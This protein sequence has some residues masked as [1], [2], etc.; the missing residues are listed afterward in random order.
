MLPQWNVNAIAEMLIRKLPNHMDEYESSRRRTIQDRRRL[1]GGLKSVPGLTVIP[2]NAN[3]VFFRIPADID[4]VWLR[5]H[6]LRE[7]GCLVREC[8]N[9]IGTDSRYFRVASRPKPQLDT[10]LS[11]LRSSLSVVCRR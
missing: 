3:F 6:L 10:F 8:G 1:E 9:K 7:H 4:G 2:S 5:N 11:A